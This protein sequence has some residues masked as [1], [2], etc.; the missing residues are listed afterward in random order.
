MK[1]NRGGGFAPGWSPTAVVGA[2]AASWYEIWYGAV[3]RYG[4][5]TWV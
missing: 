5:D 1:Q 3:K 4:G 2:G